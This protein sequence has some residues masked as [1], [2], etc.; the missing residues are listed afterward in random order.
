MS[1]WF[2]LQGTV[3]RSQGNVPFIL[4]SKQDFRLT[5]TTKE[6]TELP[7]CPSWSCLRPLTLP[8][9]N[10]CGVIYCPLSYS[11][12][13]QLLH[14]QGFCACLSPYRSFFIHLGNTDWGQT[15][16]RDPARISLAPS[17]SWSLRSCPTV[18]PPAMIL[19]RSQLKRLFLTATQTLSL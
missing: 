9:S 13:P 15:H 5:G 19:F 18:S 14:Q 8:H 4:N 17:S 6:N 12:N 10:S 2:I 3:G 11:G 7:S 1:L 16:S